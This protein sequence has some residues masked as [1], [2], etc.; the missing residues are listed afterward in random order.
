MSQR[1]IRLLIAFD[2][3]AY[4][5][6]QRQAQ[7]ESTV[8]GTLEQAFGR[9]CGDPVT[10]YG[11]GRT[12]AGV[13]ALGMVAHLHTKATIPLVAFFK[14][15]NSLLPE[16][17]RILAADEAGASFHSRFDAL[18]KTYRYDF[19]TRDVQLPCRRKYQAH[20]PGY[21]SL[22]RLQDCLTL[23]V[24]THDFASFERAGSRDKS[25]DSGRGS[26]RTLTSLACFPSLTE[27][28][29]WSLRVT[30]DGFLRQMVRN[31]AGT[32]IEIAQHKRA[33]ESLADIL[34]ARDRSRAGTTAPACGLYLER[35]YY[36]F[37][38]FNFPACTC[39][40]PTS[41]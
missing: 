28:G 21:F 38:V 13:H 15:M 2:G 12:D 6:W 23:L 4:S 10:V 40:P 17:I 7:G 14:G 3:S 20:Y 8:Q 19:T 32:L 9:L 1:T 22:Q 34:A 29:S 41:L 35:I 5:G 27:P 24:G 37:P 31:I 26:V 11:A 36:P 18:G 16:D 25:F 33:P 30:G 39:L